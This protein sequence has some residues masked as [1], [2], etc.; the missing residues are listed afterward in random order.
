VQQPGKRGEF[1]DSAVYIL[2]GGV[3]GACGAAVATFAYAIV[4]AFVDKIA[5]NE[6]CGQGLGT[7]AVV[8]LAVVVTGIL[9]GVGWWLFGLRQWVGI[10]VEADRAAYGRWLRKRFTIATMAVYCLLAPGVWVVA[11]AA[12]NCAAN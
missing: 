2:G 12:A 8:C 9:I 10:K 11:V 6:V 7:A 1:N 3:L 5:G 4:L